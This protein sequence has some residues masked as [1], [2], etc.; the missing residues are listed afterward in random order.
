MI[1]S[2]PI[3]LDAS[4]RVVFQVFQLVPNERN[5]VKGENVDFSSNR[6]SFEYLQ[7]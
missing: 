6:W 3:A 5:Y 7:E 2:G 4:K 1:F